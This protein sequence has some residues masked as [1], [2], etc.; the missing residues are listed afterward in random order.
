[1]AIHPQFPD[2]PHAILDPSVRWF[3][4]DEALR[5]TTSDKLI[6]PLVAKLRREVKDFRDG[7]YVGATDTSRGLLTWWFKTEHLL[8]G[9]DGTQRTFE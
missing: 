6:P 1:M 3:P 5:D 9:T 2:S 7:G 4:A 8:P